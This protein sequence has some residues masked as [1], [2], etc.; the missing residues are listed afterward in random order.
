M[1]M[2]SLLTDFDHT[3]K[4][5]TVHGET[6]NTLSLPRLHSDAFDDPTAE[7]VAQGRLRAPAGALGISRVSS[8]IQVLKCAITVSHGF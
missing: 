3:H 5:T 8:C 2:S 1:N 4:D 7:A 6:L